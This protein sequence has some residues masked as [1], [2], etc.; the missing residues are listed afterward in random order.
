MHIF[1]GFDD[2]TK[3]GTSSKDTFKSKKRANLSGA[4][5][6]GSSSIF[7]NLVDNTF[8]LYEAHFWKSRLEK[9]DDRLETNALLDEFLVV[10]EQGKRHLE[11][12]V[13]TFE[14]DQIWKV[15]IRESYKPLETEAQLVECRNEY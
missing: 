9:L 13:G 3:I 8:H 15:E 10:G 1:Q 14:E 5:N 11:D 2:Q 7:T 4:L 12:H 6:V